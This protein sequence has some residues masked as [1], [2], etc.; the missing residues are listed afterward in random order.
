MT[1]TASAGERLTQ[2]LFAHSRVALANGAGTGDD[3]VYSRWAFSRI[4]RTAGC[5]TAE[6][7][8]AWGQLDDLEQQRIVLLQA[9]EAERDE[10]EALDALLWHRDV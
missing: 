4:G 5:A 6:D 9:V 10:A 7:A 2:V 1:T 3:T 8:P